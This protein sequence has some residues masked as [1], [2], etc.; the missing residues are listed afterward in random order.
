MTWKRRDRFQIQLD[1]G[2]EVEPERTEPTGRGQ[3]VSGGG[4]SWLRRCPVLEPVPGRVLW[5][6]G[7]VM[8][9]DERGRILLGPQAH[10]FRAWEQAAWEGCEERVWHEDE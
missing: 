6:D 7:R 4:G 10:A 1:L 2:L 9:D 5:P 3:Q 8:R